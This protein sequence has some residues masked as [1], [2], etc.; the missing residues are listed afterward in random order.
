MSPQ[1]PRLLH[2]LVV[3]VLLLLLQ[4]TTASP[5]QAQTA[6]LETLFTATG[7]AD[8]YVDAAYS[9]SFDK[10]PNGTYLSNPCGGKWTGVSC[11]G[12][13]MVVRLS[14]A[15]LNLLGTLPS[16]LGLLTGLSV[17]DVSTNSLFGTIPSSLGQL[18]RLQT[19]DLSGNNLSGSISSSLWTLPDLR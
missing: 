9:W 6:A 14:L 15:G 2:L 1:P 19:V 17:L 4:A 16:E 5:T 3:L 10:S 13:G 12:N 11:G 7:G 8:W 18:R